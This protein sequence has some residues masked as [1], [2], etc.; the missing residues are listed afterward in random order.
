MKMHIG[1]TICLF[2]SITGC[3]KNKVMRKSGIRSSLPCRDSTLEQF[4]FYREKM[5]KVVSFGAPAIT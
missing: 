5:Q 3:P 1:R 4:F 2:W